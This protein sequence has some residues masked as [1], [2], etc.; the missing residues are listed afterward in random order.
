MTTLDDKVAIV[1]GASKGIGAAI[2]EKLAEQG[3]ATV[4][5]YARSEAGANQLLERIKARG[6][7][8]TAVKADVSRPADIKR[9]F[10]STISE[11]GKVDV[12]VN[13][14]ATYE[15][16]PLADIDEDHFDQQ[17]DL[18]VRGLLFVSQAAANAF[19]DR[20]GGSIV[21]ISS[22]VSLSPRANGSVYSA[23]KAAVDAITKSLSAELGPRNIL[24]NAV[25]PGATETEGFAAMAGSAEMKPFA[26][27]QTPLGRMG[28]P[29]DIANVVAFLASDDAAWITGQLIP[30]SGGFR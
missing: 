17:F 11:F 25:L 9:L 6:G 27:S 8:A 16:R 21:N 7:R 28:R 3:A 12:V 29:V 20:A 26:I 23:S 1:T 19:G 4:V 10:E 14:A 15:F 30:V 2:A 5:N 22:V 24:V 18:N 13:N